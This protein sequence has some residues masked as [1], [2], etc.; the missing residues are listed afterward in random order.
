[1][2][3]AAIAAAVVA[4]IVAG[5]W[6]VQALG[7]PKPAPGDVAAVAAARWLGRY[8]LAGSAFRLDGRSVR[9][10]CF[11]GWFDSPSGRDVRGTL[12]ELSDGTIV[13]DVPPHDLHAVHMRR[14]SPLVSLELAGCTDVLAP[15]VADFALTNTIRIRDA[16]FAGHRALALRLHRLT[17]FVAPKTFAPLGIQLAGLRSK[18][19]L[20]RVTQAV[21]RAVETGR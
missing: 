8:R 15:R 9:G 19:W 12:L 14:L 13:R 21:L 4:A 17:I 3:T 6:A 11:H 5:G 20:R 1:M 18:I 7:L 10:Q 16:Q 2:R